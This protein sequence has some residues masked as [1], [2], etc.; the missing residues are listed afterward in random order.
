[1]GWGIAL[2]A[3]GGALI[4]AKGAEKAADTSAAAQRE[5]IAEQRR[6]FDIT[7]EQFKPYLEAGTRGLAEYERMIDLRDIGAV[8]SAFRFGAE[9]FEQYRDPGY[10]FRV[11]E[12]L[13]ALDRRLAKSGLRGAGVRPRA[14][15]EL[16]QQLGSQEFAAARGR[17]MQDYLS[18]VAREE[19]I[20][21]RSY[22]DPLQRYAGLAQM[23]RGSAQ[24]LGG[25]RSNYSQQLGQ[26]LSSIGQTQAA[27]IL[28]RYGAYAAG[29][30]AL[31]QINWGQSQT[32]QYSPYENPFVAGDAYAPAYQF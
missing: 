21:G 31:G 11:S 1:M 15:M 12:G 8:P 25:L 17:A 19:E 6:Q 7:Q 32:P 5:A 23:G 4:G 14:L 24:S 10:E 30:G 9:E 20:Y 3:I 28:G 2:G 27:G 18:D 22:L 26:G 16:G 29:L 13:R